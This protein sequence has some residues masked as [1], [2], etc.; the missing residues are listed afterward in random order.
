M[1]FNSSPQEFKYHLHQDF[2]PK[3]WKNQNIDNVDDLQPWLSQSDYSICISILVS[4]FTNYVIEDIAK[5]SKHIFFLYK[6]W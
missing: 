2:L 1:S 6:S 3:L 5:F 4:N